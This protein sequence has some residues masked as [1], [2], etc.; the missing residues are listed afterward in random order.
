VLVCWGNKFSV[1]W[2]LVP[3]GFGSDWTAAGYCSHKTISASLGRGPPARAGVCAHR[4]Y[5][6][7]RRVL[8]I[9]PLLVF[10]FIQHPQKQEAQK[11]VAKEASSWFFWSRAGSRAVTRLNP[12]T[13]PQLHSK[14]PTIHH[15]KLRWSRRRSVWAIREPVAGQF[16]CN[17]ILKIVSIF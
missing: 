15:H 9:S 4:L 1:F 6:Q 2:A 7:L 13:A 16:L 8:S 17:S 5:A 3:R 10:C 14:L 12:R 11:A